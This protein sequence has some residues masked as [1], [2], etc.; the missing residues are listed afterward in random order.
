MRFTKLNCHAELA[1]QQ[2]YSS[3]TTYQC[4]DTDVYN[5]MGDHKWQTLSAVYP[6]GRW[7]L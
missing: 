6:D 4:N 5:R 7:M 1:E 3:N 2:A